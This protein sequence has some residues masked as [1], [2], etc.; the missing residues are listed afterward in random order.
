MVVV[1]WLT[2]L[3]NSNAARSNWRVAYPGKKYHFDGGSGKS[4]R[5][6]RKQAEPAWRTTKAQLDLE[7]ESAKSHRTEPE[8]RSQ[9]AKAYSDGASTIA[10]K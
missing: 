3:L 7:A 10:K 4:D 2:C 6:A 1:S 5:E 8:I 9:N